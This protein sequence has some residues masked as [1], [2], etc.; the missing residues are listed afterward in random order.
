[1]FYGGDGSFTSAETINDKLAQK[2]LALNNNNWQHLTVQAKKLQIEAVSCGP[3]ESEPALITRKGSSGRFTIS[4]DGVLNVNDVKLVPVLDDLLVFVSKNIGLINESSGMRSFDPNSPFSSDRDLQDFYFKQALSALNRY[5]KN[6]DALFRKV[7]IYTAEEN[8]FVERADISLP[9]T[10]FD[11]NNTTIF[12]DK[13]INLNRIM[14]D[15]AQVL[16]KHQVATSTGILV[17]GSFGLEA[18]DLCD[19]SMYDKIT[20]SRS[21]ASVTILNFV[22]FENF[23]TL[24]YKTVLNAPVTL[25]CP[26]RNDVLLIYPSRNGPLAQQKVADGFYKLISEGLVQ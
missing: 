10:N 26:N 14:P 4:R 22:P 20:R 6:S 17:I 13:N 1:M 2:A 19:H 25:K 3:E 21:N 5:T 11:I 24:N 8:G 18:Q 12:N 23:S 15:V 7:K 16:R 9:N